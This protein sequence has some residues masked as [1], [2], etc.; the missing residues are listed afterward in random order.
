MLAKTMFLSCTGQLRS[1]LEMHIL[2]VRLDEVC[3]GRLAMR[4]RQ[5]GERTYRIRA[6]EGPPEQASVRGEY[7]KVPV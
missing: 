6:F 4:L 1:R 7:T 3:I 5:D 2:S